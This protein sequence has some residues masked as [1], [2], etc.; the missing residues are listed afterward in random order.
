[1]HLVFAVLPTH[2]RLIIITASPKAVLT[3]LIT[4]W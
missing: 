4:D 1:M 2:T 3:K